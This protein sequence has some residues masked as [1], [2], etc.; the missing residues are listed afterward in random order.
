MQPADARPLRFKRQDDD[1]KLG[2]RALAEVFGRNGWGLLLAGAVLL[3]LAR[4]WPRIDVLAWLA[5]LPW[6]HFLR[7]QRRDGQRRLLALTWLLAWLVGFALSAESASALPS[8]LAAAGITL[9]AMLAWGA[10]AP[11][12]GPNEGLVAFGL[13]MAAA[14]CTLDALGF[15]H[16]VQALD[17]TGI[18]PL[19]RLSS[20]LGAPAMAFVVHWTAATLEGQLG[21]VYPSAMRRHGCALLLVL[22]LLLVI[23]QVTDGAP[24]AF[25]QAGAVPSAVAVSAGL[26]LL[27]LLEWQRREH[28][29]RARANPSRDLW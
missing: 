7:H 23:G 24:T 20:S 28:W 2:G 3:V 19:Q 1:L 10:L 26:L 4:G 5:P 12:L 27:G 22:V 21:T 8:A 29:R 18:A 17:D 13:L 15:A 25:A 16:A 9:G 11:R 14:A 6:L